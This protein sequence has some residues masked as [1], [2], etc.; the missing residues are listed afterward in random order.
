MSTLFPQTHTHTL[1]HNDVI[2]M[3]V[4][5]HPDTKQKC[6]SEDGDSIVWALPLLLESYQKIFTCSATSRAV[7]MD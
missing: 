5:K 1:T 7:T 4:K 6:L 2:E 3:P